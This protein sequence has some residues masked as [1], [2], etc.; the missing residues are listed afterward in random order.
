MTK[1]WLD[2]HEIEYKVDDIT[3]EGNLAAAQ[4]LGY[5]EAPV[6]VVAPDGVGS[7]T[8]W[9]GFQPDRLKELL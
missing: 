8:H 9:S 2:K 4:S 7:E 1:R 6:V 3:T 5:K